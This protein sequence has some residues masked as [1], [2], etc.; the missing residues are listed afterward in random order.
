MRQILIFI[1]CALTFV[2]L[3]MSTAMAG[4]PPRKVALSIQSE[5]NPK[6]VRTQI[7]ELIQC[8]YYEDG[9]LCF[10]A[11]IDAGDIEIT[12]ENLSTNEVWF[13]D[14]DPMMQ[15]SYLME[16]NCGLGTYEITCTTSSGD[17]YS[18]ILTI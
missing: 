18:G 12:V 8:Y 4:A 17:V 11:L 10:I 15:E 6:H 3:G 5:S 7:I 9:S 2:N 1:V 16:L 13:G 14:F